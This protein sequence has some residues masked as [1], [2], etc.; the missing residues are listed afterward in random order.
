MIPDA[1]ENLAA[2]AAALCEECGLCCNGVLFDQV[3]LQPGDGVKPLVALGLKI[4]KRRFFPQPCRALCG[5]R[6]TIYLQRP[7]RCREFEC[8]QFQQVAG[9]QLPA[10]QA[11]QTIARTRALVD[12]VEQSLEGTAG[13]NRRK[14]LAQRV[15]TALQGEIPPGMASSA[16]SQAMQALQEA[17]AEHFRVPPAGPG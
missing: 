7:V 16:L 2:A 17:L 10:A 13:G 8:Y 1:P 4:K 6:C 3:R 14:P 12:R 11:R 9:G 15:A 5:T